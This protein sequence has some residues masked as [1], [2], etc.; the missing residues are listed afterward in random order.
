M[1]IHIIVLL[2]HKPLINQQDYLVLGRF[3]F[4]LTLTADF[5]IFQVKDTPGLF[6]QL[7][8]MCRDNNG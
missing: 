2:Y 4:G 3:G 6:S 1:D 5:A 7:L 8:V